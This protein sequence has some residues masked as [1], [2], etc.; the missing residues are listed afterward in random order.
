MWLNRDHTKLDEK[1]MEMGEQTIHFHS[2]PLI[3]C[4]EYG[5]GKGNGAFGNLGLSSPTLEPLRVEGIPMQGLASV[6][7]EI[8]NYSG[9]G[10]D[11]I[12]NLR[13][14]G[15]FNS[16][17]KLFDT[18]EHE[19]LGL[20]HQF[21]TLLSKQP[22]TPAWYGSCQSY[23]HKKKSISLHKKRW[24]SNIGVFVCKLARMQALCDQFYKHSSFTNCLTASMG[25][26]PMLLLRGYLHWVKKTTDAIKVF[27]NSDHI[28][29]QRMIKILTFCSRSC[30][31]NP[32][33][34]STNFSD[35][36]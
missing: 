26:C 36:H 17:R 13:S 6:V 32:T 11:Q 25:S 2:Y 23:K 14:H 30:N 18:I 12:D 35:G 20:H 7:T 1:S 5:N 9:H 8:S 27:K 19:G 10:R 22:N 15:D 21:N 29:I 16:I 4:K 34:R 3:R 33:P 28:G 24:S 31:F